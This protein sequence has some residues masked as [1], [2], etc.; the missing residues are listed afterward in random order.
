MSVTPELR[1]FVIGVV[2]ERIKEL[3]VSREEFERLR[4]AVEWNTETIGKLSAAVGELAEAQKRT[5]ER[6]NSLVEVQKGTEERID[7][8]AEAQKRTE[9]VVA[10]LAGGLDMLRVEVG[11]LSDTVGFSLEDLAKEFLPSR[12]RGG[13]IEVSKLERRYFILDGE[14]VEVN[15]YGEG[16]QDGNEVLVLG[17]VKSRIY[18]GDVERFNLQAER[19]RRLTGKEAFKLMFSFAVHPSAIKESDRLRVALFTAYGATGT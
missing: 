4:L 2:E 12:L 16:L 5:E 7:S 3:R 9:D 19:I 6:I 13:G 17:K 1:S 15:L 8:L 18:G 11:R 14:E 10:R